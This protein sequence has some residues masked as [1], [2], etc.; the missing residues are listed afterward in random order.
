MS[1]AAKYLCAVTVGLCTFVQSTTLLYA[2]KAEEAQDYPSKPVRFIVPFAPGGGSDVTARAIALKL[3]EKWSQQFVIDNRAGAAGVIGVDVTSHA[4]PDGY[5]ICLISASHTVTAAGDAGLPYNLEKDLQGI[6]QATSLFYVLAVNPSLK[7]NAV[8]DLIA[9]AKAHPGTLNFGSA[10]V[11]SLQHLAGA[12]LGYMSGA[13]FVHVPYKGGNLMVTAIMS[14]ETQ[15][16]ISTMA[17]LGSQAKSG[18]LRL[19]AITAGERSPTLPELPTIAES[20]VP[21]YTVYQWYG[22]LTGA[23]VNRAI[24]R[25]LSTAIAE[26]VYQPDVVSR[27]AADGST[28]VGNSGDQFT[29]YVKSETMKWRKLI[30]EAGL[31]L[32]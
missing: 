31:K 17:S 8:K 23:R 27:F 30:K 7:G 6:S 19:L 28:P 32:Q 18:R 22:I 3:S 21:G 9:A 24:V 11:G 16:S 12:M 5:T 10:G 15:F 14:G 2:A 13:D 26:V 25:K 29:A 20:G 1:D 4:I